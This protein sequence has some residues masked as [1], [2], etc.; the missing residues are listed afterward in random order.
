VLKPGF[1]PLEH[2][3]V[4]LR[5]TEPVYM[6]GEWERGM[7]KTPLMIEPAEA[8]ELMTPS[9]RLRLGKVYTIECNVKVRDIGKIATEHKTLLLGYHKELRELGWEPDDDEGDNTGAQSTS[10]PASNADWTAQQGRQGYQ[11]HQ[12]RYGEQSYQ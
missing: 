3:I 6:T 4:Y 10:R 2:T 8:K 9:S 11:N 1:N 5:G 7:T 12:G